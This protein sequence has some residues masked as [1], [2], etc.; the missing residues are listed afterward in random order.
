MSEIIFEFYVSLDGAGNISKLGRV[1]ELSE[2][3]EFAI[4]ANGIADCLKVLIENQSTSYTNTME[5]QYI[6]L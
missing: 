6:L 3:A 1:A 2:T 4:Y 5:C